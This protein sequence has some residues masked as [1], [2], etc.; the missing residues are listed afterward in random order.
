M[1]ESEGEK[2]TNVNGSPFERH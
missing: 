2:A 1:S